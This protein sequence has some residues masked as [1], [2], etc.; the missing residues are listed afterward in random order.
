VP[1]GRALRGHQTQ[2]Y[3]VEIHRGGEARNGIDPPDSANNAAT[4]ATFTWSRDNGSVVF[5]IVSVEGTTIT[6]GYLGQDARSDLS[7]ATWSRSNTG[8]WCAAQAIRWRIPRMRS[9]PGCC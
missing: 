1:A 5:P 4:A 6:L 2:L 7:E 8:A 3:R 9:R